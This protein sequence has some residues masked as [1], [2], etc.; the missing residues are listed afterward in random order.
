LNGDGIGGQIRMVAQSDGKLVIA[1]RVATGDSGNT[2]DVGVARLLTNNQPDPS[3]G[4]L[5]TGKRVFGMAAPPPGNGDDGVSCL[6][7]A[8]GRPVIA[9][10]A[11]YIGVDTDFA[12]RR[13]TSSL[14]FT[15]GF[16]SGWT[17]FWSAAA[18][19]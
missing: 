8:A 16:E 19:L 18:L 10:W 13:L 2:S 11:E 3:F 9:G 17:S 15:D 14:I 12:Y 6:V 1:A 7:L 5:G 4:G